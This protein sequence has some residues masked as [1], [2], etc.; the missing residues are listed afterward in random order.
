MYQT[1]KIIA[2][3]VALTGLSSVAQASN[4]TDLPVYAAAHNVQNVQPVRKSTRVVKRIEH[5]YV[6]SKASHAKHLVRLNS[7]AKGYGKVVVP[8]QPTAKMPNLYRP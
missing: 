1:L 7:T 2:I 3:S 4:Q 5:K 8:T 6:A